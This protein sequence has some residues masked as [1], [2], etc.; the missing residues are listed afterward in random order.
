MWLVPVG[1]GMDFWG[2]ESAIPRGYISGAG[3]TQLISKYPKLWKLWGTT[4]GGDGITTFGVPDKRGRVSIGKD[5]QGG[6]AANRV[7][8]GGSGINGAALGAT[9]G[10]ENISLG[11][12]NNGPHD[13]VS[14]Y[15]QVTNASVVTGISLVGKG[16]FTLVTGI[17]E[18][19]ATTGSQ[20]SGSG[21]PFSK[22]N[23]GIV[24][25]YIIRAA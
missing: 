15:Y 5:N 14:D 3:G 21:T 10:A 7:T 2:P 23:P 17:S 11:A 19:G 16:A 25:N 6:T 13:H 22:M 12:G 20:P 8:S 4:H 18:S 1:S 9:G 24:C